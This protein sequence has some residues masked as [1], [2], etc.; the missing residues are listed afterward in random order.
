MNNTMNFDIKSEQ[1]AAVV[2][3]ANHDLLDVCEA[4]VEWA[5]AQHNAGADPYK[6]DFVKN[7]VQ[8]YDRME[9]E[10]KIRTELPRWAF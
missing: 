7:A 5:I 3:A 4:V 9:L 10:Y 6:H 1:G 8:V 2:T